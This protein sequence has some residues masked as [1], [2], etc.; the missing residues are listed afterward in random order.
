MS[1]LQSNLRTR[2]KKRRTQRKK[3]IS[4]RRK[5]NKQRGGEDPKLSFYNSRM[6]EYTKEE[7]TKEEVAEKRIQILTSMFYGEKD[8][9]V[10][11]LLLKELLRLKLITQKEYD[12]P[13]VFGIK[14]D[15]ASQAKEAGF[16]AFELKPDGRS[17]F[18]LKLAGFTASELKLD[19][20]SA[21]E[22]KLAGF[23][24]SELKQ[25]G[26][27]T[28]DLQE[29]GFPVHEAVDL[30]VYIQKKN[31]NTSRS[32]VPPLES[33]CD[34][35]KKYDP[36]T[37]DPKTFDKSK[38]PLTDSSIKLF[39]KTQLKMNGKNP[40]LGD[41][42]VLYGIRDFKN[43]GYS[44]E[45]MFGTNAPNIY[46]EQISNDA[47]FRNYFFS[48]YIKD[49][50]TKKQYDEYVKFINKKIDEEEKRRQRKFDKLDEE[51]QEKENNGNYDSMLCG[52]YTHF[53][54]ETL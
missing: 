21:S 23:T 14:K 47:T 26:F 5:V 2:N 41:S 12:N 34:L 39:I 45:D 18:E 42:K 54:E 11:D 48:R 4:T 9:E 20:R 40:L 52:I 25:A 53:I 30:S 49:E 22:L 6:N 13:T 31:T 44:L 19:G 10:I 38:C 7:R 1:K 3:R 43:A 33:N 29:A 27:T 32:V 37:F 46:L 17:A 8:K 24:A 15:S 35:L 28:S 16:N 51:K 36:K 50:I